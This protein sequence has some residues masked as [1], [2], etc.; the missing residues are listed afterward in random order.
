MLSAGSAIDVSPWIDQVKGVLLAGFAGEGANEAIADLLTGKACPCG[1][2]NETFPVCLEDTPTGEARGNGFSERYAE[3][4]FV[5]YR[6]YDQKNTPVQFPFGFGLSYADFEYS[7]LTIDKR[8]ETDYEISYTVKNVSNV[9]GKEISQLYVR[10]VFAM[11]NRPQ[12]ELKGFAKTTLKAGESKRVS[13]TLRYRDFAYYS[14]NLKKWYVEN[15][16]FEILIGADSRD[17]RLIGKLEI[18]LPENEQFT[19]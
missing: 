8:G 14:T 10:D 11:V 1:K 7:D 17:I 5:G 3:G 13:H 6:W 12:K 19:R 9:D 18:N 4:V 16:A 2:L 15:G